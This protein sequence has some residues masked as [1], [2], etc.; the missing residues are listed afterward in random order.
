MKNFKTGWYII[1]T[2][3]RHEKK[4]VEQLIKKNVDTF[5]PT[6]RVL[7]QW[8]DRSKVVEEPLF[9]SYV[10]VYLNDV[11]SF[12][13]GADSEGTLHYVRIGKDIARVNDEVINNIKL[14][15]NSSVAMEVSSTRFQHGQKITICEGALSGLC[16]E[17]IEVG[18]KQ[19]LL[20][21]VDLLQRNILLCLPQ[22][23][24]VPVCANNP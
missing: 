15:V 23:Y 22:K 13:Y 8:H 2:K 21:R 24:F 6:K 9:P 17:V 12:H 18:K 1:Y 19:K 3:Y 5:L 7:K 4:V 16:G 20:V 14:S 10:F 11:D